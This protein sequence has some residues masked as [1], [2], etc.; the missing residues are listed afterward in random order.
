MP[1][2]K[3]YL[4][5][6][7]LDAAFGKLNDGLPGLCELLCEMLAVDRSACH[8][9]LIGVAAPVGQPPINVELL[10]LPSAERTQQSLR[11]VAGRLRERIAD[12]TGLRAAVRIAMPDP[13][14]YVALK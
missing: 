12:V 11:T 14:T 1:N 7:H 10:L 3:I 5:N 2:A 6:A 4:D 8:L 13:Q 9:V